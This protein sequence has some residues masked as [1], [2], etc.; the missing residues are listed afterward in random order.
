MKNLTYRK[1]RT[2]IAVIIIIMLAAI[3]VLSIFS[4]RAFSEIIRSRNAVSFTQNF[5][6]YLNYTE[7][8]YKV[9]DTQMSWI[10]GSVDLSGYFDNE[11][12]WDRSVANNQI[13][14]N[15]NGIITTFN[16]VDAAV[17]LFSDSYV[18]IESH[19]LPEKRF[20]EA[21]KAVRD[22][23][24]INW[25]A[26]RT[27]SLG[28]EPSSLHLI[29]SQNIYSY[30][31]YGRKQ[32]IAGMI[33]FFVNPKKILP[34]SDT[35]PVR[36]A[37]LLNRENGRTPVLLTD[38]TDDIPLD[39]SV[40]AAI[41][42]K[43]PG[44]LVVDGK[45][46]RYFC[47]QIDQS[48][49]FLLSFIPSDELSAGNKKAVLSGLG[50]LFLVTV[51]AIFS[52]WFLTSEIS[53]PLQ[54]IEDGMNRI[55]EG[56]FEYRLKEKG[57]SELTLISNGVNQLL[58]HLQSSNRDIVKAQE[59]L[60]EA[61]LLQRDSRIRVL[62]FQINPHF[63]YNTLECIRSIAQN[64]QIRELTEIIGALIGIFRYNTSGESIITL[65]EELVCSKYY[66]KIIGIRFSDKYTF[67]F[68]YDENI[69][70]C[71]IMKMTLQPILENAVLHGLAERPG[72][73][74]VLMICRREEDEI[75]ISVEDDGIGISEDVLAELEEKLN[76]PYDIGSGDTIG[77]RNVHQRLIYEYG[78]NNGLR[79]ESVP[80]SFTR[81]SFRIPAVIPEKI[82]EEGEAL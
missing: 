62:Q 11:S 4:F 67:D 40:L 35:F 26:P 22:P 36:N 3:V 5:Q 9:L 41:A 77:L 60:Y 15:L 6:S 38:L 61:E 14:N 31:K 73:G 23:G 10:S 20:L 54:R 45:T 47:Q 19:R 59:R 25:Q 37:L 1:L 81:V 30:N 53:T 7:N 57:N 46:Y 65:R 8:Q 72:P 66:A 29:L 18:M 49:L 48:D 75:L 39:P 74:R 68:D 12:L 55:S 44:S 50:L 58:D 70:D 43:E 76:S 78:K 33:Y 64:Y 71:G 80:G 2:Q 21:M 52:I 13:R 79:I 51:F 27:V 17:I 56:D 32:S 24:N 63:L 34:S 42:D 16:S 82:P 28:A 69:L